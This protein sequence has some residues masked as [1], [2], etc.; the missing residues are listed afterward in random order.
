MKDGAKKEIWV[1]VANSSR[2]HIFKADTNQKLSL[3]DSIEH[4]EGRLHVHDLVEGEQGH[5]FDS[6]GPGRHGLEPST[7]PRQVETDIFARHLVDHLESSQDQIAK[8]YISASPAFLGH[9][10]PLM[11][12]HLNTLL[13]G[14]IP[15]DLTTLSAH[16]IR[17]HF[18]YVL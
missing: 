13:A 8:L 9:I 6:V 7:D 5:T 3:I 18:P 10:R 2:A 17:E 14:E 12:K 11:P 16:E 15:K 4:P 1:L